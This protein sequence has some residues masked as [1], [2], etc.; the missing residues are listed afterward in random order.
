M[1]NYSSSCRPK[2]KKCPE[3]REVY[4]GAPRRH[5]YAEKMAEELIKLRVELSVHSVDLP[6]N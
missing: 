1:I 2:V 5:R 3:C 4:R 6:D